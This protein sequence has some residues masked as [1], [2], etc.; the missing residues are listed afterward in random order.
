MEFGA[1]LRTLRQ[2]YSMS[3]DDLANA[4]GITAQLVENWENDINLPDIYALPRIAAAFGVTIDQL[5][6]FS[7]DEFMARVRSAISKNIPMDDYVFR[8]NADFLAAKR[9]AD[10]L[11]A[12]VR[13]MAAQQHTHRARSDLLAAA[14]C[15]REALEITPDDPAAWA[16]LAYAEGAKSGDEWLDENTALTDYLREFLQEHP[17]NLR[18]RRL[19]VE[20]LISDFRCDEAEDYIEDFARIPGSEYLAFIYSGDIA[21]LRGE[22]RMAIQEWE[23]AVK[24]YPFSWR[25]HAAFAGRLRRLGLN[26][27]ALKEYDRA[28]EAQRAP[29]QI[30]PLISRAQIMERMGDMDEAAE[31]RRRIIREL[32]ENFGVTSGEAVN[33]HLRAIAKI[34]ARSAEKQ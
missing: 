19:L 13:I 11:N 24:H 15:A 28:Y 34:A 22:R 16:A 6:A 17:N 8:R 23:N 3:P 9:A 31:E 14:V 25:A 7:D 30:E 12:A 4:L 1:N 29:R 21:L 5:F 18:A 20:N 32:A 33:T 27:R 26:N 10:P 2:Q